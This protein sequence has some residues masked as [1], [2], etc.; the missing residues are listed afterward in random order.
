[1]DF[2]EDKHME[3]FVKKWKL[4]GFS[5]RT[6][7]AYSYYIKRYLRSGKSASDFIY[8]L[9]LSEKA[10][11]T[12]RLACAAL[13]NYLSDKTIEIPKREKKLPV[14]LS[15]KEIEKMIILTTNLKHRLVIVLLYSAGLRVSELINLKFEDIDFYRN[16]IHIK[17]GKGSKDRITLLSKKTKSF[18]RD[19]GL[20]QGLIFNSKARKYS[21]RAVE[22][23][24]KKT[25]KKAGIIKNVTPHIL[26][27]SFATHLLENGVDLRIIQKLLGHSRLETTQIYTHVSKALITKIKS[28]IDLP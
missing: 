15:K 13:R 18:L 11:A 9:I 22:S 21:I 17:K 12:V 28:P 25:A 6:I 4:K 19:Y 5:N 26:R 8:S 16:L 24:I 14:V 1:M 10:T 20:G 27:H 3:V 23:I 7:K 2:K